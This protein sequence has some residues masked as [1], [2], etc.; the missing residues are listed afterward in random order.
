[1]ILNECSVRSGVA[2]I[3]GMVE[4]LPSQIPPHFQTIYNEISGFQRI[5]KKHHNLLAVKFINTQGDQGRIP[6]LIMVCCSWG[7]AH[8]TIA[9]PAQISDFDFRLGINRNAQNAGILA[10]FLMTFANILKNCI[11]FRYLS[12]GLNFQNLLESKP[13]TVQYI[14]QR[15]FTEIIPAITKLFLQSF[16]GAFRGD[17]DV[18]TF[19]FKIRINLN[20][21]C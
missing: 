6:L 11:R 21:V 8:S 12:Q 18:A 3:P 9:S 15:A 19:T 13:Q 17:F 10:S 20:V 4:F 7:K 16:L 14:V 5:A 1:M 2:T